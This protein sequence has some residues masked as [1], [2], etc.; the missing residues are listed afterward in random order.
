ML[1]VEQNSNTI[2]NKSTLEQQLFGGVVITVHNLK[3][4]VILVI[5]AYKDFN[6][7]CDQS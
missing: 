7:C 2:N 6:D 4:E 3:G 5:L 1:D